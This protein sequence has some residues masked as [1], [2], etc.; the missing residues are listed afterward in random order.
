MRAGPPS[1]VP[2][3]TQL[4][5]NRR[6]EQ[7][8]AAIRQEFPELEAA[9][10]EWRSPRSLRRAPGPHLPRPRDN[11]VIRHDCEVVIARVEN[12]VGLSLL[13][14]RVVTDRTDGRNAA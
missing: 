11:V 5:A 14:V 1:P 12:A 3:Q 13:V 9:R 6:T 8:D 7:L 4:Y 10:I 2:A